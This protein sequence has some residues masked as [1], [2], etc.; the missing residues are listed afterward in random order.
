MTYRINGLANGYNW[1]FDIL[2]RELNKPHKYGIILIPFFVYFLYK[3]ETISLKQ[4]GK[5]NDDIDHIF[6]TWSR[7]DRRQ[8]YQLDMPLEDR[9]RYKKQSNTLYSRYRPMIEIKIFTDLWEMSYKIKE[10]I[11]KRIKWASWSMQGNQ[12]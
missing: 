2:P 9:Y 5:I 1:L 11:V 7:I 3:K 4:S 12:K 8:T 6:L 10:K